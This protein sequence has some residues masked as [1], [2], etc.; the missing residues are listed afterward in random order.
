M[1]P[2]P[3]FSP[4]IDRRLAIIL[5]TLLLILLAYSAVSL[6]WNYLDL[7]VAKAVTTWWRARRRR[8]APYR[9]TRRSLAVWS[10]HPGPWWKIWSPDSGIPGGAI[11]GV[12]IFALLVALVAILS[13]GL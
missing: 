12:V 13:G 9:P 2:V 11:L 5:T 7:P 4:E 10:G 8:P 3:W 1:I 6:F